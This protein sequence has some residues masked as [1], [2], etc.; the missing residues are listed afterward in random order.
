MN[1]SART[2][3]PRTDEDSVSKLPA[4]KILIGLG[5]TYLTPAEAM[6]ARG[7]RTSE[8]LLVTVLTAWLRRNNVAGYGDKTEPIS[9]ANVQAA[10]DALREDT[11]DPLIVTNE[12]LTDLLV[13][14]K[15]MKQTVR[16]EGKSF[17]LRYIDW[18]G[19]EKDGRGAN[20]F[21]VAEEFGV[22]RTGGA[23]DLVPDLVLFVNGIPLAVI[24]CKKRDDDASARRPY[25]DV[26]IQQSLR[27]QKPDGIPR[28]FRTVQL[29]GAVSPQAAPEHVTL[30]DAEATKSPARYATVGTP[31]TFWAGWRERGGVEAERSFERDV[32]RRVNTPLDA[33]MRTRMLA[34]RRRSVVAAF[35]ALEREP[36][37]VTD[38]DRLLAAVFT[39]ARVLILTRRYSLFDAGE[40]KVARYQQ[41]FCVETIRQRIRDRD[42]EGA[43]RGGVVWHTQGSGK[44]LT[45]VMLAK[46]IALDRRAG[47]LPGARAEKIVLVTDRIDLDDQIY[48]T[49]TQCGLSP[50]QAGSGSRLAELLKDSESKVVAT[51]IGKFEAAVN[52]HGL[53]IDDPD[54]YVLVDEGHRTQFG[55]SH[56]NMRRALPRACYIGFTGTPISRAQ[57][58]TVERF[59]GLIDRYALEDA[60]AD[61]VVV[62]LRYEGR[63]VRKEV[64]KQE[65][66]DWFE[67]Y[68]QGLSK[69]QKQGLKRRFSSEDTVMQ[70]EPVIRRIARDISE[71]FKG[72]LKH[73][74]LKAQLVAP[75][76]SAAILYKQVLDEIGEVRSEVLISQPDDREGD[77][78]LYGENSDIVVRFWRGMMQRFGTPEQYDKRLIN[79]FKNGD[80]SDPQSTDPEIMIVVHK[81]LT[82]FDAPANTVLYLARRVKEH[83]LLQAIARVNRVHPG[84]ERGLVLDYRGVLTDLHKA[85]AMYAVDPDDPEASALGHIPP[86]RDVEEVWRELPQ[87]R[88]AL[89]DL[90]KPLGQTGDFEAYARHLTGPG[91]EER[92]TDF[93][94]RFAA[95]ARVLDV[96]LSSA[97]FQEKTPARTVRQY[98]ED[99]RFF[100]ELRRQVRLRSAEVLDYSQYEPK[101]RALLNRHLI[102]SGVEQ[103]TGRIDLY[104]RDQ[105][106]AALEAAG[107]D[108]S[109]AE[110]IAANV[111]RV[112]EER[113]K[114]QDPEL[115]RRFS[116]LLRETIE[117]M[118]NEWL[119]AADALVAVEGVEQQVLRPTAD[120]VP[121]QLRGRRLAEVLFRNLRGRLNGA[122]ESVADRIDREVNALAIVNWKDNEDQKK[123]MRQAIDDAIMDA[124]TERDLGL[125]F[126]QVDG[127]IDEI[128]DRA[129][130]NL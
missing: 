12:K 46:A 102:T 115:Y 4:L 109:K 28:L 21:H 128:M 72:F 44:S 80:T 19:T 121:Q 99:L 125:T 101:I 108:S 62:P 47:L 100:S 90:F 63:N 26:A 93:Y 17:Q 6:E 112:L 73:T 83:N 96:A 61:G 75:S 32:S 25:A 69:D 52:K 85:F 9:E 114:F 2:A 60:E 31:L 1:T 104:D 59:G 71:H 22:A 42:A 124:N 57:R 41:Y 54:V 18:E 87:R 7:G 94:D 37:A 89:L 27:N 68:T 97:T 55:I 13:L 123:M 65:I 81:L 45:M 49:F 8:V 39:P 35:E 36:R 92:R 98:Q 78:D 24:E 15:G 33:P 70:A 20:V 34:D 77:E 64:D 117:K 122:T 58:S 120:D 107:T 16:G 79:A 86:M 51:T 110:V 116:D 130:A 106:A 50:Q 3:L 10:I 5:W 66:D 56:A 103:M 30:E 67:K 91:S 48:K 127:M 126:E 74:G 23:G 14:G 29:L 113:V 43:R 95:F 53:K 105:R 82:G 88:S 11:G 76:K 84:K 118:R 111:S 129:R 40:K 119:S 38:Q